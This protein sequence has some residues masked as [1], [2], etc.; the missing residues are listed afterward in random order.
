MVQTG[1][2]ENTIFCQV[3]N[4]QIEDMQVQGLK[5][6]G[7]HGLGNVNVAFPIPLIV[8][9]LENLANNQQ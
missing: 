8:S 5:Y 6:F 3:E 9:Y 2:S 4:I 1:A 7:L